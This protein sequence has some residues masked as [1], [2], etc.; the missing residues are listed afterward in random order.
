MV[1]GSTLHTRLVAL[2]ADTTYYL[3]LQASTAVGVGSP[4]SPLL[5]IHTGSPTGQHTGGD[6]SS[7][8]RGG[9]AGAFFASLVDNERNLGILAGVLIGGT[10]LVV[11][12]A[13][14][15]MKNR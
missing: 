10:C 3:Q 1:A 8:G 4:S 2:S 6:G 14:I 12:A 11:C 7:S 15:I 9:G 5:Q 13:I